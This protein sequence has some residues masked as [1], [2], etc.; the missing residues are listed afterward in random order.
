MPGPGSSTSIMVILLQE[1]GNGVLKF[2]VIAM[3]KARVA[4]QG[5]R[6][7]FVSN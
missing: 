7:D 4:L 2:E 3:I 6:W 5:R 1:G